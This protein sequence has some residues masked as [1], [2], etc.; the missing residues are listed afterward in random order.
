[1]AYLRMLSWTVDAGLQ[2]QILTP[3]P[4]IQHLSL[5]TKLILFVLCP[6]GVHRPTP[7]KTDFSFLTNDWKKSQSTL[8]LWTMHEHM[9]NWYTQWTSLL[10]AN[11]ACH[12][13]TAPQRLRHSPSLPGSSGLLAHASQGQLDLS[14]KLTLSELHLSRAWGREE[15]KVRP[16]LSIN[17][18]LEGHHIRANSRQTVLWEHA[19]DLGQPH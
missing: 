15:K 5:L 10:S 2:S 16:R 19:T 13:A 8:V 18:R 4:T 6:L 3:N 14:G 7:H 1:M 11:C 12:L 9:D 17:R